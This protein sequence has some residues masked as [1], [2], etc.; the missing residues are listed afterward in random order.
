MS[1]VFGKR[2]QVSE[3]YVEEVDIKDT[4]NIAKTKQ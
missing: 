1:I 2:N 4:K 3:M